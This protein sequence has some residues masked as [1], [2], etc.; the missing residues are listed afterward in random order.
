MKL[1]DLLGKIEGHKKELS[2]ISV[3][4]HVVGTGS[5]EKDAV[6][7][8]AID[9][10]SKMEN[11]LYKVIKYTYDP[12][13]YDPKKPIFRDKIPLKDGFDKS[14][15]D[16]LLSG[17]LTSLML[18]L[19]KFAD[20]ELVREYQRIIRPEIMQFMKLSRDYFNAHEKCVDAVNELI[21][22]RKPVKIKKVKVVEKAGKIKVVVKAEG[23]KKVKVVAKTTAKKKGAKKNKN[24]FQE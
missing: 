20:K 21:E 14:T 6:V 16:F 3:M 17:A 13:K 10:L 5:E 9:A 15:Q 4:S 23:K 1:N 24:C 8:D 22:L 7:A 12:A 11:A 2:R 18:E 19:N